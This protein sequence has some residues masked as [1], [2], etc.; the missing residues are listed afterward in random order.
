MGQV[1]STAL[2]GIDV[3]EFTNLPKNSILSLW[4]SYNLLGEGWALSLDQFVSIF[5]E[6]TALQETYNFSDDQLCKLFYAFD[7]DQNGLVDALEAIATIGIMS[8]MDAVDKANFTFSAFDFEGKGSLSKDEINLL[9]RSI[10]K[11]LQKIS[12]ETTAYAEA[13]TADAAKF[14][15]LVFKACDRE[16]WYGRIT[17]DE[18]QNYC[19]TNPVVS[20]WLKSAATADNTTQQL[21]AGIKG[22]D[23]RNEWI[24]ALE[25]V[26]TVSAR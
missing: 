15:T 20:S 23:A 6:A 4:L 26:F 3:K 19:V 17:I 7:T 18:F 1:S 22:A 9:F 16:W 21:D 2:P 5:K 11:G 24:A 10:I 8:G 13:T 25:E 14:A 12:P